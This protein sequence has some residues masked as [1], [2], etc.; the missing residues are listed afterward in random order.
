MDQ[1]LIDLIGSWDQLGWYDRKH[2]W[3]R[4]KIMRYKPDPKHVVSLA[5]IISII[6]IL[7]G[8][9]HGAHRTGLLS[10]V[11]LF[12]FYGLAADYYYRW[13]FRRENRQ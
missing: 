2:I 13:F 3:L 8:L 11:V 12:Y 10:T 4:Y 5:T 6:A 7:I 1:R 9:Q